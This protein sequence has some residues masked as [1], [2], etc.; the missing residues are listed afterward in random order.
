MTNAHPIQNRSPERGRVL[1]ID[2]DPQVCSLFRRVLERRGHQVFE[3]G[4]GREG[5]AT[6]EKV[7]PEIILLDLNLPVISGLELLDKFTHQS[8][9]VPVIIVSGTGKMK[10]A[11]E[12][13]RLGAWDYLIK[14]LPE[15]SVLVHTVEINIERS[16]LIRQ[17]RKIRQEIELHLE[18]I[19][20]D[21]EAGRKIQARLFPPTEWVLGE[22]CF[23]YRVVSPLLLSGDFV[24]Y[25]RVNDRF[26]VFYCADV[27]GHGVSSALVT[28]LLKSLIN[29]YREHYHDR[30]DRMIMEPERLLAQLNKEIIGEQL[31]KHL[32]VFYGVLDTE[33]N[34]LCCA[35]GGHYPP[36]LL[37]IEGK[38]RSLELKGMAVGLFPFAEFHAETLALPPA[39]RLL[40]FSD[41]ALDSLSLPSP[42]AKLAY[43]QTLTTRDS[44]QQFVD[45]ANANK[46]LP[47][48]LTVLSLTRGT[49]P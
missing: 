28:V 37:F 34:T 27:S 15:T 29:K 24:D 40:V 19:R 18:K 25:F 4:D 21:E 1:L 45:E 32:T 35:N 20:E 2:D 31:G 43:L 46:N 12:A 6:A 11:V 26:A 3:A 13:L 30:Q 9:D 42:E 44:L 14:P 23:R 39:F 41:G 38:V 5:I 33:A 17:N 47:D 8:P 10:D 22:Y 7:L 36:P 16:R 48:D 49:V